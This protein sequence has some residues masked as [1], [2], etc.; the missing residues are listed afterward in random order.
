MRISAAFACALL[1]GASLALPV[2]ASAAT[3]G[4]GN[5]FT[6]VTPTRVLDTRDSGGPVGAGAAKLLDLSAAV[7]S[8]ATAVLLNVTAVDA[9]GNTFVA[10]YPDGA[11]VP[12]TSNVNVVPGRAIPNA[13][14]VE[15]RPGHKIDLF[16]KFGSVQLIVD[17]EGYYSPSATTGL[18]AQNPSRVLDTRNGIG[19]IRADST[20]TL[21]LS[22]S[23]PANAT[24]VVLNLT[25]TNA[26]TGTFVTA[27][28]HGAPRPN[29]S[30]LN[31]VPGLDTP[32]GVTVQLSSDRKVDL[33]NK[34]GSVDLVADLAGYYAPTSTAT[35]STVIPSRAV[36]TRTSTPV[37]SGARTVDLSGVIPPTATAV[38]LN[39]TGT[40]AS[41]GTFVTVAPHGTPKPNAS[42][43]N[44]NPGQ[45]VSNSATVAVSADGQVDLYNAW[46]TADVIVDVFAYFAPPFTCTQGCVYGWGSGYLGT[47][48]NIT[49]PSPTP[50]PVFGLDHV[51]AI[52]SN[53]GSTLALRGDGTVWA[54]GGNGFGQ[55]GNGA[56]CSLSGP[57]ADVDCY[58]DVPVRVP[59]LSNVE[60]V[61][62]GRHGGFALRFDGTVWQIGTSLRQVP[63]LSGITAIAGGDA[64]HYALRNDGTVWAWGSNLGGELGIGTANDV[65]AT[66]PVQVHGLSGIRQISVAPMDAT[67]SGD[68]AFALLADF[69]V[70]A[71]GPDAK[72]Y[73]TGV[74]T[75]GPAYEPVAI[76]G[77]TNI[78]S[79]SGTHALM[80]SNGGLLSWGRN[81][82]GQLG[83]GTHGFELQAT[84]VPATIGPAFTLA[85][86]VPGTV[87][88]DDTAWTWG[89]N[90]FGQLGNGTV[91]GEADTPAQVPGLNS[92]TA[93]TGSDT[94]TFARQR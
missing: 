17:L 12:I 66:T 61:V 79:I 42:T 53:G 85:T 3:A 41:S 81:D 35:F 51:T 67:G 4:S 60:A 7:P 26:T 29:T 5:G 49:A 93:L 88:G 11:P 20:Y 82:A 84:P 94:Q 1:V 8:D 9:T 63:G 71:W 69:S 39:L 47:R 92:I 62:A 86:H 37:G 55:L 50:A 46:G 76:P 87:R 23:V 27:W 59:G 73:H 31:L 32:N 68:T 22:N 21:D 57:A 91:G 72:A 45:T 48:R 89:D 30:S 90:T 44:L 14:T 78:G 2:T 80:A 10:V 56:S 52:D 36:D 40:N 58:S 24:A 19:A 18:T 70:S 54:W 65:P 33:Y 38:V 25:G 64:T 34:N 28:P 15:L 16:N 83:N 74:A 77:L 43:L 6:A 13:V 75:D